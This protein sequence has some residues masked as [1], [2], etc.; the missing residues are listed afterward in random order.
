MSEQAVGK[1][2]QSHWAQ[3]YDKQLQGEP[4]KS[5]TTANSEDQKLRNDSSN[6]LEQTHV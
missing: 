5:I 2:I 6:K 4:Y 3:P 1:G